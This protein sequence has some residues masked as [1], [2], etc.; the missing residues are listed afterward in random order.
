[1]K[2]YD[3]KLSWKLFCLI[4][5]G[6][7]LSH[8]AQECGIDLP[9][10]SRLLSKLE[11]ELGFFL[12]LHRPRPMK[13]S[14]NGQ[15]ILRYAQEYVAAQER[16]ENECH[17]IG[18]QLQKIPKR[19]IRI[20]F[21]INL[22]KEPLLEQLV[23]YEQREGSGVAFEFSSD[24][25]LRALQ[26]R[27]TDISVGFYHHD[28]PTL[29]CRDVVQYR[30]P[31]LASTEYLKTHPAPKTAKDLEKH[32]ILLRYRNSPAYCPTLINHQA[33]GSDL[34]DNSSMD[35][36][37]FP[38]VLKGDSPYCKMMLLKGAGISVDLTLG[39]VEKEIEDGKVKMVLPNWG[40]LNAP[41]CVYCRKADADSPLYKEI[42]NLMTN[43]ISKIVANEM[44]FFEQLAASA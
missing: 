1:M 40:R 42:L 10:A 24:M 8:A 9:Y 36:E 4:G 20:S 38:N 2:M 28:E 19:S 43:G 39:V 5:N 11:D 31:L 35:L 21:P 23:A 44:A 37:R 29:A 12:V 3:R 17:Q 30:F 27:I 13:L 22:N 16:L 34:D 7:S 18:V 6:R 15:K 32:V 25:G 41:I 33:L 26:E 14:E